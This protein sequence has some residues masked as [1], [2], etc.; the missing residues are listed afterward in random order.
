MNSLPPSSLEPTFLTR[1]LPSRLRF[2]L[3]VMLGAYPLIAALFVLI[4]PMVADWPMMIRPLPI[5][6][7]M[8]IGMVYVVIPAVHRVGGGWI[9][10]GAR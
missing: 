6:P 1:L 3:L 8:V 10:R 7:V 9:A 5:V 4:G 2:A